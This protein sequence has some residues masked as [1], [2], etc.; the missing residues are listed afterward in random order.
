MGWDGHSGGVLLRFGGLFL[1]DILKVGREKE[2]E[3]WQ[4]A[5]W[6]GLLSDMLLHADHIADHIRERERER[7]TQRDIE[8]NKSVSSTQ[9]LHDLLL[10]YSTWRAWSHVINTC[11]Y[12]GR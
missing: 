9:K 4:K 7:H 3:L 8:C 10:I 2:R 6:H 12:L 11:T 1:R 5:W